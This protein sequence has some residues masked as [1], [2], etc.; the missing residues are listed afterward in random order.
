MKRSSF[1]LIPLTAALTAFNAITCEA[2]VE[3]IGFGSVSGSYEDLSNATA[4][5]LDNGVAGNQLGG[6]GSGLAFAGGETFLGLPDRGPNAAPYAS[7]LDD[8]VAYINRFHSL[9]LSLAPNPDYVPPTNPPTYNPLTSLPFVLTPTL[10][11]TTLLYSA[12]PLVYGTGKGLYDD[13]G[14]PVP[15]GVPALNTRFAHY[16]TGRSDGFNPNQPSSNSNNARLDPESIR[17]S[18]DGLSVFI[19]DEYGPYVY[20]FNRLTGQRIRAF[21]LPSNLAVS[22]LS[23]AGQTE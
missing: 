7:S 16:F 2:T 11:Q 22:L 20:Q 9:N 21:K 17:V 12:T 3:F 23:P 1:L 18:N 6:F 5:P 13:D 15:S 8:T 10:R 19:S 4:T 14:N